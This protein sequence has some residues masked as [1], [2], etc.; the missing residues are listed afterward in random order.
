MMQPKT[1]KLYIQPVERIS[2]EF[3]ERIKAIRD[4]NSEMPADFQNELN[5]W[6]LES[7]SY[8]AVNQ[9]LGLVGPTD[10]MLKGQQLIEVI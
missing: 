8:I 1:V 10:E 7:I 5:K 2:D 4:E 6:A 3:I 9:R